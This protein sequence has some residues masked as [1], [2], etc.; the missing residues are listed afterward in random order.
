MRIGF[1]A[2][3]INVEAGG[4]S[5]HNAVAIIRALREAGHRVD[6]HT[7]FSA[8]NAPPSDIVPEGKDQEGRS[9]LE[10]ERQVTEAMQRVESRV[11]IFFVYGHTLVWGAGAYRKNGRVPVAVYLD[12][13]LDSMPESMRSRSFLSRIAHVL[14]ERTF[15]RSRIAALDAF[16]A[17]SDFLRKVYV[18]AGFPEEKFTIVPNFFEWKENSAGERDNSCLLYVGRLVPEKGVDIFF[19]ALTRLPQDLSW[20]ARIVGNGPMR[21]MV[22]GK[23]RA[24]ARIRYDPWMNTEELTSAYARAGVFVH[25][26]RWPEP[27][28]RTI[29]EAMHAGLPVVVPEHGAAA[30]I[31]G[32]AGVT[33]KNGDSAAL[34]RAITQLLKEPGTLEERAQ[35]GI[36]RSALYEKHA[37]VP[38]LLRRLEGLVPQKS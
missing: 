18:R 29:V 28:G 2:T 17:V 15:G 5:H 31:T 35:R 4:G 26:A 6:V 11:D 22:E 30:D 23:V 36:R 27:F 25:P 37:I 32:D 16:I 20:S 14:W 21:S 19:E 13:Y 8:R 24:D 33:F 38:T 10:F 3:A 7:F 12:N 34:A 9:F 1:L